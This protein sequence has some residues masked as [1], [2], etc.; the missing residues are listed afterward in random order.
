MFLHRAI[1]DGKQPPKLQLKDLIKGEALPL[2][3]NEQ[4]ALLGFVS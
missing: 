3:W 4:R 1:L 2:D